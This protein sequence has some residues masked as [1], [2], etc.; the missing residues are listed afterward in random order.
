MTLAPPPRLS[1]CTHS[2]APDHP[3]VPRVLTTYLPGCQAAYKVA[4][5]SPLSGQDTLGRAV[6]RLTTITFPLFPKQNI[7]YLCSSSSVP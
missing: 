3:R 4:T 2:A 6:T 7:D 5:M 1:P